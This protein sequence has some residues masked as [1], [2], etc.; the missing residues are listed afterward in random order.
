MISF[1]DTQTSL[2]TSNQSYDG[3]I[4]G[5]V[6]PRVTEA[7]IFG[8]SFVCIPALGPVQPVRFVILDTPVA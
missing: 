3:F 1:Y 7:S 8:V 2:D 6:D 5:V 4:Q